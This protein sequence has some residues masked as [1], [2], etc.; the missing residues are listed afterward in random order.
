MERCSECHQRGGAT[1]A[2]PASGGYIKHHEQI[3]EMR[4]SK[5]ADGAG[6]ELTCAS[7]HDAHIALRYPGVAGEGLTGISTTCQTCHPNKEV[8]V[9]GMPKSTDCIDCHMPRVTKSAVGDPERF[10]GDIRTHLMAIEPTQVGQ[11]SEDGTVALSQL[12]LDFACRSCHNPDGFAG[13][14]S[15]EVLIEAATGYHEP[16]P[17]EP[18]LEEEEEAGTTS[19]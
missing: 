2:I 5:H 7:C 6:G 9:N 11:F 10:T 12:S 15:D 4:A 13:E 1:N 3:N 19:P 18:A 14:A 8:T 16:P 17:P